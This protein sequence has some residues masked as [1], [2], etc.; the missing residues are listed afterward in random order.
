VAAKVMAENGIAIDDL[1]AEVVC[2]GRPRGNNV[3]DTG[4]LST[5]V[6]RSIVAALASRKKAAA[7]HQ[8]PPGT[9]EPVEPLQDDFLKLESGMFL[10]FDPATCKGVQ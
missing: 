6:A 5:K 9:K 3:H 1:H 7:P 8:E 2:Q 4:N 10:H